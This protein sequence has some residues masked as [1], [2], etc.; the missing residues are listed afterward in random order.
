MSVD[1]EYE[2]EP[3]QVIRHV[4]PPHHAGRPDLFRRLNPPE[5]AERRRDVPAHLV[6]QSRPDGPHRWGQTDG[7]GFSIE[8][9][10]RMVLDRYRPELEG[11]VDRITRRLAGDVVY[12]PAATEA[13][14]LRG[15]ERVA[16]EAG[17]PLTLTAVE[18]D[19][20]VV[21][22]AGRWRYT[23]ARA[24][25]AARPRPTVELNVRG[26]RGGGGGSGGIDAFAAQV[27]G[28]L[29][30]QL[31]VEAEGLPA[32]FSWNMNLGGSAPDPD[33]R[34]ATDPVGLALARIA[35]QTGLTASEQVRRVRR[36]VLGPAGTIG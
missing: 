36:L 10:I 5:P 14:Y 29:G 33:P 8:D 4:A 9:L 18:V 11:D 31:V 34:S 20:P 22:L 24:E 16:A 7:E 12:R 25:L 32:R 15:V 13:E 2:L 6:I 35:E 21:V 26:L 19:R 1:A 27:G 30:L 17:S 28:H 3:G 23:P